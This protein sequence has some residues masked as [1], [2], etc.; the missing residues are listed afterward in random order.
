MLA[1]QY[2]ILNV[3]LGMIIWSLVFPKAIR[4]TGRTYYGETI[5]VTPALLCIPLWYVLGAFV[6]T[7]LTYLTAYLASMCGSKEPL[8]VA[9]FTVFLLTVV[10]VCIGGILLYRR[11]ELR[12]IKKYLGRARRDE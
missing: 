5:G 2:I 9:N 7:W 10:F 1:F 4:F 8:S 3:V 11:K 12:R 6:M